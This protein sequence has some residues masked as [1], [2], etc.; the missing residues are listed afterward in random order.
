MRS[1]NLIVIHCS[2]TANG[3][4]IVRGSVGTPTF[5]STPSVI[6]AWHAE[7]GFRRTAPT[8]ATFNPALKSIGYHHIVTPDGASFTGRAH[9]E[10]GAHA[11][12]SNANSIGICMVGIDAYTAKQWDALRALV[13]GVCALHNIPL[14]PARRNGDRLFDGLCGHRDTSPDKNGNGKVEPFEWLKTCPGFDVAAWLD[15]GLAP[16]QKHLIVA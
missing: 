2:A 15:G 9:E 10:V 1:I 11:I 5:R 16:L 7:R 8:A 6:D 13:M 14:A 3:Q 12:N 4:P